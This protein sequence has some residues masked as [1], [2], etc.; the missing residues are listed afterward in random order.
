MIKGEARMNKQKLVYIAHPLT[1]HGTIED[2]LN[3]IDI[4]CKNIMTKHP[5]IVPISP[6]HA[7][8][9]FDEKKEDQE[10]VMQYCFGLLEACKEIWL[11]GDWEKSKG[12]MRE[13]VF[14]IKNAITIHDKSLFE[15]L[16][17]DGAK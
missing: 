1:T 17:K 3:R 15:P 2:N 6:L 4:I 5:D 16:A 13:V 10:Q 8:R 11:F 7:F 14:S 9:F 12:C